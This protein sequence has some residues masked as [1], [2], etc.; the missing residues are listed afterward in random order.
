MTLTTIKRRHVLDKNSQMTMICYNY[1]MNN[2]PITL[3]TSTNVLRNSWCSQKAFL[4]ISQISCVSVGP[5]EFL[6]IPFF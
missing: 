1:K 5:V 6:R 4:K 3:Y 2:L